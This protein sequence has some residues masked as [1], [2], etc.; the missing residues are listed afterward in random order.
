MRNFELPGRSPVYATNAMAATSHPLS[1]LSA[2]KVLQAGGNAVD[3]ALAACAVQCVVEPGSTGIGG[4]CFMLFSPAGKADVVA[5][6]GSGR[7]PAQ[8]SLDWYRGDGIDAIQRQSPHAV[9]VPGAVEAWGRICADWGSWDLGRILGDAISLAEAGYAVSPRVHRDWAQEKVRLERDAGCKEIYLPHGAVP[10]VGTRHRNP[11]LAATLKRIANEGPKAF[12]QGSIARSLV[13]F[14]RSRGGLHTLE[15]FAATAG[16]YVEPIRTAYK[17][18]DVWECPPNGQG[19]IALMMLNALSRFQPGASALSAQRIHLEIEAARLAYN[20]RNLFLG[21]PDYTG[22][23]LD[24]MLSDVHAEALAG[25]IDPDKALAELPGVAAPVTSNTVY[26]SVVDRDRNAVSFINSL[27]D[28]FGSCLTDPET[29][30][31]LHNRGQSFSLRDD[32]PN[33]MGPRKRP[34]HTLIP[35]M[36]TRGDRV[37]MPFG[38]MGG[39]YQALGHVQFLSRL[40]EYGHDLQ[41]CADLPRVYPCVE[42][43]TVEVESSLPQGVVAELRERGH[44]PVPS[45]E[46]I[47]GAQAVWIDWENGVLTGASDPRKDGC[48]LGY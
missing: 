36:V 24:W 26:V 1:T 31:L 27:F 9:T 6:N 30:V 3:A 12:Y 16:E 28:E 11:R 19:I 34:L 22:H 43:G 39:H 23:S 14:L 45:T 18:Y 46:P 10:A 13:S 2:V 41:E 47:G 48:A 35:G 42:T 21:D 8:C 32:H 20:E 17:G 25:M 29:G 33:A 7:T 37:C 4:D 5:Y 40:L 38:V 44:R 15:D